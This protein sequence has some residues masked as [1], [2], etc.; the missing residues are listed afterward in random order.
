MAGERA[1]AYT[2][3]RDVDMFWRLMDDTLNAVLSVLIGMEVLLIAF[4]R[5][6]LVAGAV[7]IVVV[8]LARTLTV[9]LPV[10]LSQ[11]FLVCHAVRRR[12]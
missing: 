5:P 4:T 11:R 6:L 7:A 12:C 3:R 1:I 10:R 8:L 9:G 2:M